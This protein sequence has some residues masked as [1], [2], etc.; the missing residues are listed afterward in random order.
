[1]ESFEE[2]DDIFDDNARGCKHA[3]VEFL[4]RR[5]RIMLAAFEGQQ[6]ISGDV[7]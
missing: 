2:A 6:G 1:M 3:I 4:R 5:E 7:L